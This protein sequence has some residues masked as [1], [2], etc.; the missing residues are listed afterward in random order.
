MVWRDQLEEEAPGMQ[1]FHPMHSIYR[2]VIS[3]EQNTKT[4]FKK[5]VIYI[6]SY[7]CVPY[8]EIKLFRIINI[9]RMG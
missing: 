5:K 9:M 7:I 8:K 2:K 3:A 1:S 4:N 6:E